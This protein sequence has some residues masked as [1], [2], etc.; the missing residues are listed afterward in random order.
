MLLYKTE[1]IWRAV[2][3]TQSGMNQSSLSLA[4]RRQ[5]GSNL[6]QRHHNLMEVEGRRINRVRL[7]KEKRENGIGE[8]AKK[9][10]IHEKLNRGKR[11]AVILFG[12]IESYF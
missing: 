3:L 7:R 11:G 8:S 4:I 12:E 5:S 6:G 9:I 10:S 1:S 2:K